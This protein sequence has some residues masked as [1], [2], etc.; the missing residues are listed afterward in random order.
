MKKLSMIT[1]SLFLITNAYGLYVNDLVVFG[2][3]LSCNGN[4]CLHSASPPSICMIYPQG[5]F[6][7]GDVWIEV[8]AEKLGI[9]RPIPSLAGGLN[10]AYGSA[11]TGWKKSP[12]VLNVGNQIN[13]FLERTNGH[14]NSNNLYILWAGGNDIKNKIIPTKLISNLKAHIISL[15]NA[16]AKTFVIPNFPPLGRTPV[17]EGVVSLFGHSLGRMGE[18]LNLLDDGSF[19]DEGIRSFSS[20][21]ADAGIQFMNIQLESM[22]QDLE[23]SLGINIYRFD[24]YT[25]FYRVMENLE[26]YGLNPND[27]LFLYDG[28]HPSGIAHKLIAEEVFKLLN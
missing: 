18:F 27:R 15:A 28:F 12:H 22:L 19:I 26:D 7:D 20:K 10:F 4:A 11:I 25:H 6:T 9:D 8:L 14:A 3:S 16:G 23:H 17:V 21:L 24:A 2:D 1:Y 5:R 13:A